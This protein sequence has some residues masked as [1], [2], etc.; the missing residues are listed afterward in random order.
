M[1]AAAKFR[2]AF[3]ATRSTW[4]T[5]LTLDSNHLRLSVH[6]SKMSHPPSEPTAREGPPPETYIDMP[7]TCGDSTENPWESSASFSQPAQP[8]RTQ[9]TDPTSGRAY[10]EISIPLVEYVPPRLRFLLTTPYFLPSL[11]LLLPATKIIYLLHIHFNELPL[12]L[13]EL[14]FHILISWIPLSVWVFRCLRPTSIWA[15][16][17]GVFAWLSIA[18]LVTTWG[19]EGVW[20]RKCSMSLISVIRCFAS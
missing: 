8:P 14:I 4:A 9:A 16:L 1:S 18:S 10:L 12:N 15:I 11:C 5:S 2:V 20:I 17:L 7:P 3:Q 6:P 13:N 19:C